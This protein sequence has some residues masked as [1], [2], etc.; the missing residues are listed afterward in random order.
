M[1]SA[2]LHLC[3]ITPVRLRTSETKNKFKKYMDVRRLRPRQRGY[4][5]QPVGGF[6]LFCL[7]WCLPVVRWKKSVTGIL[8]QGQEAFSEHEQR[9]RLGS[10]SPRFSRQRWDEKKG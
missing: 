5:P 1:S 7:A 3:F 2:R 10:V 4:I 6:V 8:R 9:E